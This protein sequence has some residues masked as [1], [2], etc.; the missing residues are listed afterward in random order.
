[1]DG[2][3][4]RVESGLRKRGERGGRGGYKGRRVFKDIVMFMRSVGILNS[5]WRTLIVDLDDG[6][7][8]KWMGPNPTSSSQT[9]EAQ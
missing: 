9:H 3:E 4:G 5:F 2:S 7:G 6:D 1:M 8:E